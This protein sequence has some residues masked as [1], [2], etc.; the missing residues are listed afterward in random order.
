M[1]HIIE[2][3][4]INSLIIEYNDI[5]WQIYKIKNKRGNNNFN[6]IKIDEFEEKI[7]SYE[8]EFPDTIASLKK[9]KG[10]IKVLK[11]YSFVQ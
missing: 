11:F 1:T 5:Q 7:N 6:R 9:L 10:L 3:E 8:F 2:Q 4:I